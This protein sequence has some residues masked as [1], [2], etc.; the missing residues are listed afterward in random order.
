MPSELIQTKNGL[1]ATAPEAWETVMR[2]VA[3]IRVQEV[4]GRQFSA[5]V[6]LFNLSDT[7]FF[8]LKLPRARVVIPDGSGF[9]A[10]NIVTDG[11]L[12]VGGTGGGN[13]WEAGTA[14]VVN[15]D[16][17]EYDFTSDESFVAKALCFRRSPLEEYAKRFHAHDGALL[18]GITAES[19][20]ESNAGACFMRYASFVWEEL[21][22][23]D[24]LQSPLAAKEME[25]ALS[26]LL[27][28]ALPGERLQTR[29]QSTSGYATYI[30]PAEEYILGN[31]NQP[32]SVADIAEAV[33]VSVP[34]I[35]RAFRKCHGIGPKAFVKR[36]RLDR[37]RSDLL[38]AD[39]RETSV[40]SVATKHG[41]WHLSQFA[42]DYK[43]AFHEAPSDTLRRS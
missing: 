13:Q 14:H 30:K 6:Q 38:H 7:A 2:P 43:K 21:N 36:R 9:V 33:G 16:S 40:T 19:I 4:R 11:Q 29:Q 15:H 35:N 24:L 31:L 32:I 34:T 27:L 23:G 41:F 10:V 26:A 3:D 28:S 12:R 25:G 20:L 42:A 17:F 18:E 5:E 39:P 22:R 1:T 37:V 8:R